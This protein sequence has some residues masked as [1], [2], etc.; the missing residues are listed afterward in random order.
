MGAAAI[1]TNA[2]STLLLTGS[3]MTSLH[4]MRPFIEGVTLVLWAWATWW[5]PDLEARHMPCALDIYADALEYRFP[6]WDVFDRQP[7]VLACSRFSPLAGDIARDVVDLGSS[8]DCNV[9]GAHN[10]QLAEFLRIQLVRAP[11]MSR[12]PQQRNS[13]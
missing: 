5:I 6:A 11:R 12:N 8:V 9:L 7:A 13:N 4:S 1:S 10:L 2:G 3:G